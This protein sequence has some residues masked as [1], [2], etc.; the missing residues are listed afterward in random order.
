ME[1]KVEEIE[2]AKVV[3][4]SGEIDLHTSPDLRKALLKMTKQR[5]TPLIIDLKGVSYMD[6]SAI[7]TLVETLKA[8]MAYKGSLRLCNLSPRVR[9]IFN[10]AKLDK[11]F[12]IYDSL[13]DALSC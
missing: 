4:L 3:H 6:S 10:F 12:R 11:V 2:T 8:M 1:L 5:V 13:Q 7:A 9:E